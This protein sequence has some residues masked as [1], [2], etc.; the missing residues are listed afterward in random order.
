MAVLVAVACNGSADAITKVAKRL[1]SISFFGGFASPIGTYDGIPGN[2][3]YVDGHVLEA[4]A[5]DLFDNAFY[6]GADYGQLVGGHYY[7]SVGFRYTG[8]GLTADTL[9]DTVGQD[10]LMISFRDGVNLRQYDLD[11][12]FHYLLNDLDKAGWS[13]YAGLAIHPG[14]TTAS[15]RGFDTETELTFGM[16]LDFGAELKLFESSYGS[17]FWTLASTNNWNFLGTND[18]PRYL[19]FGGA[20]KYY[21]RM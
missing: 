5:K 15:A 9:A 20:I 14:L 2:P 6:L 3:F 12:C 1:N 17:S 13:P 16:S 11:I 4:E 8:H 10:I 21:F 7:L 18:R 19:H